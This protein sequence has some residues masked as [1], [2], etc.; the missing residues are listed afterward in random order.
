MNFSDRLYRI[1][2]LIINANANENAQ[3]QNGMADKKSVLL[4]FGDLFQK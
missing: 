4:G 2:L 3:Q 1:S